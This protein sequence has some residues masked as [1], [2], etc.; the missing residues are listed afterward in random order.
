MRGG[1]A[2][3]VF[4]IG[5]VQV[6]VPRAAVHTPAPVDARLQAVEPEDAR[7]DIVGRE[8]GAPEFRRQH[9]V[10]RL[11]RN[12]GLPRPRR[13]ADPVG[14]PMPAQ[15]SLLGVLPGTRAPFAGRDGIDA[16]RGLRRKQRELLVGDRNHDQTAVGGEAVSARLSELSLGARSDAPR[17]YARLRLGPGRG[18]GDGGCAGQT[19]D[20]ASSSREGARHAGGV[21]TA[22][23]A[24]FVSALPPSSPGS[25]R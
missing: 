11:A 16:R 7:Q 8:R 24:Y 19:Q 25:L 9:L 23:V 22:S 3:Q 14:D 17:V 4:L 12:K 15:R 6:D 18:M 20:E 2:Q 13:L 21:Q 10:G 1:L 5:A